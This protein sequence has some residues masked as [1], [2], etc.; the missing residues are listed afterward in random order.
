MHRPLVS[1][2]MPFRNSERTLAEAIRSIELQTFEDWELLLCDDG[3]SDK[4]ANIA[5]AP[6]DPRVVVWSDGL[7]KALGT[8]L[9]ECIDRARGVYFARMDADDICYPERIAAQVRFMKENP[10]VD[11]MGT[12]MAIFGE[13]GVCLGKR[14][15]P[16]VHARICRTPALSFRMF[17]PTWLGKLS[18]FRRYR[19]KSESEDHDLLFR[20]YCNSTYANLPEILHGYREEVLDLK[21]IGAYRRSWYGLLGGYTSG[22]RGFACRATVGG[23]MLCKTVL[24]HVAVA[25][26]LRHKLVRQRA[27]TGTAEEQARGRAVW[28]AVQSTPPV[29]TRREILP[30]LGR[31]Q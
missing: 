12:S 16:Q 11:L 26:G 8:R 6:A 13:D 7:F 2:A 15:G 9:N 24:D 22:V 1:I 28:M 3:S 4:S 27:D 17:H 23:C 18:W 31:A 25:T 30:G 21:K 14:C 29:Q 20:A 10:E 19:Y 5:G